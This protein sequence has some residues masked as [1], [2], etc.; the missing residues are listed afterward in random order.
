M[1]Q[2][3]RA[4]HVVTIIV[5][6]GAGDELGM[7]LLVVVEVVVVGVWGGGGGGRSALLATVG[8]RGALL[9]LVGLGFASFENLK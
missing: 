1:R 2:I 9:L 6:D 8:G 4:L 7:E 5:D 3:V